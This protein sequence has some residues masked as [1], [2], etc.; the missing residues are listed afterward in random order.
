MVKDSPTN[1]ASKTA[2]PTATDTADATATESSSPSA[3]ETESTSAT[4]VPVTVPASPS[5]AEST[6]GS[7]DKAAADEQSS[8]DSTTQASTPET[9]ATQALVSPTTATSEPPKPLDA[10]E[11]TKP[12]DPTTTKPPFP[13]WPFPCWW[14]I[15]NPGDPGS[16]PGGGGGGGGGG[17]LPINLPGGPIVPP[18]QLPLPLPG[19]V[20][21]D[22]PGIPVE[23]LISAVT[24][25]ATAAAEL[26]FTPIT[27]PV[28][29]AP[30]GLP[31]IGVGAGAGGGGGGGGA[32]GAGGG[33][34][35]RIPPRPGV[36]EP[37]RVT[38][39]PGGKPAS[40]RSTEPG[41]QQNSQPL[42]SGSGLVPAP[43]YRAGYVEYLRAA[44][45]GEV[46]A[47]AVPGITGLLVLT[48]AG[49]LLGYRQARAG[50]SVRAGGTGR[51]MN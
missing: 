44:G 31:G 17:G 13:G 33:V 12:T 14:P 32:G 26:P 48:G 27:L 16:P 23:P 28:I 46:A 20:V 4:D 36:P 41:P 22:I 35:P 6:D 34:A 9:V 43:S 18:M 49:G 25:L 50:Q 45:L 8:L 1:T 37:P 15:P 40:P 29:V 38:G 7:R 2:D 24:G 19:E 11:T 3:T 30:V 51:F 47:V 10:S 39:K 5:E 21:P 42:S